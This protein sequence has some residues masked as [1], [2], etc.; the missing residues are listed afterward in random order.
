MPQPFIQSDAG[1]SFLAVLTQGAQ[2]VNPFFA[3]E[4]VRVWQWQTAYLAAAFY[5]HN[6][7][8]CRPATRILLGCTN[9]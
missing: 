7:T 9:L 4:I 2:G 1:F 5:G 8:F 6:K 3:W